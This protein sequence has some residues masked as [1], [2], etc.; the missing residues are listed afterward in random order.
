MMATSVF[1]NKQIV[2]DDKMME[3]ELASTFRHY[4]EICRFITDTYGSLTP[5]WKY[6]NEK[7]GWTLKLFYKKRNILFIGPRHGFFIVAFVFGDKAVE[8]VLDSHLP[9]HIKA[10]LATAR[11]YAEGRGLLIEVR[12]AEEAEQVVQLIQ[13]KLQS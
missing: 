3:V 13:I 4:S 6:Y 12:S 8:R 2:P 7:S 10:E 11:K 1:D 9:D 5:E